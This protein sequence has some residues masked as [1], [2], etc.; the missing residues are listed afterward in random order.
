MAVANTSSIGAGTGNL[1]VTGGI[2]YAPLG[3]TLPTDESTAPDAAFKKLGYISEDGLAAQGER[4]VQAIKDWN[5]NIIAQLQTE[6]SV[7][8]QFTLYSVFDE[9]ILTAVFGSENVTVTAATASTGKK[10]KVTETGTS[11]PHTTWIFDMKHEARKLRIVIPDGKV[12]EVKE[13]GFKADN[14]MGFQVTVEAFAD[15]A[16]VKAIRYYND[17]VFSA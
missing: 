4:Q 17:G 8:F 10:I 3:S 13:N 12:S 11:L 16:G 1:Q 14:L 7:R 9:D 15:S 6:H 2:L 5:A